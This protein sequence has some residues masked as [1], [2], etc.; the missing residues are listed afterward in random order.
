MSTKERI[1]AIE[2]EN[3]QVRQ[4]LE[5]VLAQNRLLL[6]RVQE[7]EG[8]LAKDSHNSSKPPLSDGLGR[9]TKSLRKRSGRKTGGQLRHRGETLR[10]VA[11]PDRVV[12]HRPGACAHCWAPLEG[13]EPVVLRERRQVHEL[14]PVRLQVTEHQALH[15][16]CQVC[17]QVSVGTFP[18]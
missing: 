3:R 2:A 13:G 17:A 7:L 12:E 1:A 18:P 9:K 5:A 11:V 14:P 8:R 16:R 6:E 10:L 4:E 15:V